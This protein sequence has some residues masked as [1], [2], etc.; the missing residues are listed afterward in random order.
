MRCCHPNEATAVVS[1]RERAD[2]NVHDL[3]THAV[4]AV[5]RGCGTPRIIVF[6]S[7]SSL[8][9]VTRLDTAAG[10]PKP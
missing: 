4:R 3:A 9:T 5:L 2:V 7:D 1:W 8:G 6:A 10:R